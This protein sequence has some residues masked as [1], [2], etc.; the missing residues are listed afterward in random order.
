MPTVIVD[1]EPRSR[2]NGLSEGTDFRTPTGERLGYFLTEAEYKSLVAAWAKG[3][4]EA[5]DAVRQREA[6]VADYRAG[7][8][9][10]TAEAVAYLKTLPAGGDG[11]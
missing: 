9:R 5:P 1:D 3:Q 11:R 8:V 2:L 4:G 7:R 10:T 6:A